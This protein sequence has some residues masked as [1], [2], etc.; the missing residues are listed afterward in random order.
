[1][2]SE[3]KR[4][5]LGPYIP[6]GSFVREAI[7]QM[8]LVYNLMLDQRVPALTKLIPVASLAYLLFPVD[9]LPDFAI[10]LGQLDDLAVV[11]MGLRFFLELAPAEVVREHLKRIAQ[12]AHWSVDNAAKPDSKPDSEVV[13]GK[14]R[15]DE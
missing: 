12:A 14:F 10:G 15:V 1:M 11:M 9:I 2:S 5:L 13:E 6:E 4:N 7:Q 8:K 3:E